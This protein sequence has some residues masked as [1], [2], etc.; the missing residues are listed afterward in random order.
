[1]DRVSCKLLNNEQQ[2]N[3]LLLVYFKAGETAS[4]SEAPAK[5]R[6]AGL[7]CGRLFY[8]SVSGGF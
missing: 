7:L 5:V 3:M 1:M 8:G 4:D 6:P 2:N